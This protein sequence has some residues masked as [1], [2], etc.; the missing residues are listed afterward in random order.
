ME[1]EVNSEMAYL[2]AHSEKAL[3]V[4]IIITAQLLTSIATDCLA[5]NLQA[6]SYICALWIPRPQ[7]IANAWQSRD[8]WYL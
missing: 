6:C 1:A 4:Q 8:M 7:K 2:G 3:F 5:S